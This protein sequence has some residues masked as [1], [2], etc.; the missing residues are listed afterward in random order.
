MN[1]NKEVTK[2]C[3]NCRHIKECHREGTWCKG[4]TGYAFG[5][6]AYGCTCEKFECK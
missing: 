3:T 6:F 5:A 4:P 2:V 1:K